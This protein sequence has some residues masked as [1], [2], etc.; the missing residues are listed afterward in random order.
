MLDH[1][2][3]MPDNAGTPQNSLANNQNCNKSVW[4]RAARHLFHAHADSSNPLQ[5]VT[6]RLSQLAQHSILYLHQLFTILCLFHPCQYLI[7]ELHKSY[8]HRKV[9]ISH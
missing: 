2:S 9:S 7:Q 3:K 4:L 1:G 5:A 8:K 6:F